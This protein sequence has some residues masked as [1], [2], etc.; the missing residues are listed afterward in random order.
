MKTDMTSGRRS[1][2]HEK[3]SLYL[4]GLNRMVGIMNGLSLE[5]LRQVKERLGKPDSK[6]C[7]MEFFDTPRNRELLRQFKKM[8]EERDNSN[9][10]E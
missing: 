7:K 10:K 2:N 1:L 9:E 3:E 5:K 4:Y 6:N 8:Q